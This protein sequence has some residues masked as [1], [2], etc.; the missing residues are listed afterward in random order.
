MTSRN[1]IFLNR[2]GAI[3]VQDHNVI[4]LPHVFINSFEALV[5]HLVSKK[6]IVT[7]QSNGGS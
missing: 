4:V 5:V 6:V 7:M 1:Y 3:I 2:S